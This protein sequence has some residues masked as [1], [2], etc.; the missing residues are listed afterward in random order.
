PAPRL[1]LLFSRVIT[2]SD[3]TIPNINR[4][5]S[6]A[7]DV[8]ALI[9]KMAEPSE[10]NTASTPPPKRPD[11]A[12]LAERAAHAQSIP[13][14]TVI[15]DLTGASLEVAELTIECHTASARI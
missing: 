6:A 9:P 4:L 12:M 14:A 2:T 10:T 3:L 15:A 11:A 5:L 1:N 13:T 7:V 8:S